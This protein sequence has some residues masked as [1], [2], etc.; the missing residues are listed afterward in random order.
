MK[1]EMKDDWS[2][3]AVM[4][5]GSG[6]ANITKT[7]TTKKDSSMYVISDIHKKPKSEKMEILRDLFKHLISPKMLPIPPDQ[8]KQDQSTQVVT[9]NG[10]KHVSQEIMKYKRK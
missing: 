9:T 6:Q 4:K 8:E 1:R 3:I 5:G 10:E 7:T 2:L